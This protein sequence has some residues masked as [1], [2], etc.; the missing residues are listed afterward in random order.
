MRGR[1]KKEDTTPQRE[2]TVGELIEVLS[3][4]DAT[5]KVEIGYDY[6]GRQTC[7]PASSVFVEADG[8]IIK[9]IIADKWY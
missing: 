1:K 5:T 7:S 6:D 4:V 9:V 3:R 8:G 2:L